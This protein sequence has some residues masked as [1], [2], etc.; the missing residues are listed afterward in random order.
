MPEGPEVRR[1]TDSLA[2]A[3]KNRSI[4]RSQIISGRYVNHGPPDGFNDFVKSLPLSINEINCKGKFIYIKLE[5]DWTIWSTLGMAGSWSSSQKKHSR[6][7]FEL[8]DRDVFFTDVRNFGTLKFVKGYDRL[9][10]KLDSLGPDMLKGETTDAQFIYVMRKKNNKTV[11]EALM[12]QSVISGVGNYLKSESLYLSKISPHRVVSTLS[13]R[14]MSCLNES[15]KVTILSSYLSGGATIHTFEGFNGEFGEY[16][17]RFAVYNQKTDP[18][19][20]SVVREKTRDGRT[21]FWVPEV[22]K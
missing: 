14:E 13:N 9:E 8:G 5:N 6:V 20:L 18:S 22:Q 7:K 21:T 17:R 19:G 15:I 12:N 11:V 10:K 1:I 2:T 3:M 4:N 16:S